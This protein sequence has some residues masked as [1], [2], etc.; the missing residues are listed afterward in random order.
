MGDSERQKLCHRA[1]VIIIQ[2]D[3]E[4]L[5]VSY[6]LKRRPVCTIFIIVYL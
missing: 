1:C 3:W 5:C 6:V 2:N 4:L